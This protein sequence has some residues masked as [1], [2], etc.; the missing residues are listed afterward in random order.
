MTSEVF[1]VTFQ[2]RDGH[3]LFGMVHRPAKSCASGAAIILLSPGVKMR[4]APHRLYLDMAER[5]A[6]L[7]YLVLRF[8]FH[9]LGDSEGEAEEE[10]LADL[11]GA[12]QVGRYIN[13]TIAAMDWMES[14]YAAKKF[15][16][17]GLCGGAITGL[18]AAVKD[19]RIVGLLGL[20]IPVILDG[21]RIDFSKYMTE[22]QLSA[23]RDGYLG[24]LV[25][26]EAWRSWIRF[27]T[28]R[29]DYKLIARSLLKPLLEKL[30]KP[31]PIAP[32]STQSE[33]ADNTNPY[34]APAFRQ[35]VSTSRP[36]Y[37]I[38]S[39][40][41]RLYWEF[42]K[43]FVERNRP[44]LDSHAAWYGVHVTK[45]ANHIFSF[46]EWEEDMLDRCAEWLHAF[47]GNQIGNLHQGEQGAFRQSQQATA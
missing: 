35:M 25:N 18:L 42:E 19:R 31:Q 14:T 5:F 30:R 15:I 12:V 3:R 9:G 1:P 11:Y 38:F 39:E 44:M 17:S 45:D 36:I 26:P 34:F 23:T 32:V 33:P 28:F 21:S 41:D 47:E 29:S 40:M 13:D 46:R 4:V 16:V 43:K 27:L 6:A 22:A 10:F 37:L 8:D 20:A 7:G 24:K 2:N